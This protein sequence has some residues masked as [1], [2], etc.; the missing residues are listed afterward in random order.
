M[1]VIRFEKE[2]KYLNSEVKVSAKGNTYVQV[3]LVDGVEIHRLYADAQLVNV[4]QQLKPSQ[5]VLVEI[6]MVYGTKYP[7]QKIISLV[8][9]E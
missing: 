8:S 5:N 2:M 6:E 7:N 3:L 1:A 4:C 9:A